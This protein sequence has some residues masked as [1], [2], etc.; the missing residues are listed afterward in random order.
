M[1]KL[2]GLILLIN[3]ALYSNSLFAENNISNSKSY[4]EIDFTYINIIN[5]KSYTEEAILLR[6]KAW[7]QQNNI[8]KAG[9]TLI[10]NIPDFSVVNAKATVNKI[11]VTNFNPVSSYTKDKSMVTGTFR[12]YSTDVRKYILK[13]IKTGS[14]QAIEATPNHAFYV[15][16]RTTFNKALNQQSHFIEIQYITSED[17]LINEAGNQ[18]QLICNNKVC[19]KQLV[20]NN[21]P[22]AVYNL[23]IYK[24]HQYLVVSNKT[25]HN[26]FKL[27]NAVLVH[28]ICE[29]E[30]IQNNVKASHDFPRDIKFISDDTT[31]VYRADDRS[32]EIILKEGFKARNPANLATS[33][34]E[35]QLGGKLLEN[36]PFI[37]SSVN[38]KDA[39]ALYTKKYKFLT[40]IKKEVPENFYVYKIATPKNSIDVNSTLLD[41][42]IYPNQNEAMVLEKIDPQQIISYK[43]FNNT[44]DLIDEKVLNLM[45]GN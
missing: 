30:Y 21:K 2:L 36:S 7:L 24:Q 6:D 20:K 8:S 9:N 38:E 31:A 40:R 12:H 4:Y 16:N 17:K 35:H 18:V 10:L 42:S 15:Q 22:I 14:I 19:S 5:G 41:L 37:S 1:K 28:N 27:N 32:P 33:I 34:Q 45:L 29:P 39:I 11:K 13:D 23:E 25:N 43:I 44:G 3:T 26:I